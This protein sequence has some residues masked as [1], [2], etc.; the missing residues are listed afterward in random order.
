VNAKAPST[1]P[2]SPTELEP[3]AETCSLANTLAG[4]AQRAAS[5]GAGAFAVQAG[6]QAG[7]YLALSWAGF[8]SLGPVAASSAAAWMS[9]AA[10]ANGGGVAAGS[11]YA[12]C[13]SVAVPL[14]AT[15]WSWRGRGDRGGRRRLWS[16]RGCKVGVGQG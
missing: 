11:L 13:Q 3:E 7:D 16:V 1:A 6:A 15:G 9:S 4:F 10:A 5:M 8:S 14:M 12:C 2:E